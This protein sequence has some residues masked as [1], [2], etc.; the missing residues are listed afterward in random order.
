M[1][2]D[3]WCGY[4]LGVCWFG[5]VGCWWICLCKIGKVLVIR[6]YGRMMMSDVSSVEICEMCKDWIVEYWEMYLRLGGV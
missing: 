4:C 5:L 3:G 6:Y 2:M 1:G